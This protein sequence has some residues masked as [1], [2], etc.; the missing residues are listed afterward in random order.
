MNK[1]IFIGS[2]E[3]TKVLLSVIDYIAIYTK[4]WTNLPM[5]GSPPVVRAKRGA[6]KADPPI[7]I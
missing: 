2:R 6:Y 3:H 5:Y 1:I 7:Y 4:L